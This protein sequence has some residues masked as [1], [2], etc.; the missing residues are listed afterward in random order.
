MSNDNMT[1]CKEIRAVKGGFIVE[2]RW[3][4]GSDPMGYGETVFTSW[5]EVLEELT[6]AALIEVKP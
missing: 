4:Y 3:P 5:Q 2:L 6:K 1:I